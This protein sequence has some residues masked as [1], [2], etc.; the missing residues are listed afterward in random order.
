MNTWGWF[1]TIFIGMWLLQ[2]LLTKLQLK[3]YQTTIQR[4]S[5][6][7]SGYLG[8]GI[9]KQKVGTGA[10]AI[11]ITNETG[12]IEECETMEGVT[13]FTRFKPFTAHNGITLHQLKA[14]LE[15]QPMDTAFKMA[16]EKIEG[17]M[18][19]KTAV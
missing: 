3:N 2:F 7:P 10:I 5:K 15:D 1:I 13:V 19:K 18:N 16:I 4:L 8:V 14:K 11:L 6:R 12:I 9:Q 17:Q